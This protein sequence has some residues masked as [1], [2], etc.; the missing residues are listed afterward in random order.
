MNISK[1]GQWCLLL[2]TFSRDFFFIH[3]LH[4]IP[5]I[6]IIIL[7]LSPLCT[8]WT[9]SQQRET[10]KPS[11]CNCVI[12]CTGLGDPGQTTAWGWVTLPFLRVSQGCMVPSVMWT[13]L[14]ECIGK[15]L[16]WTQ[17]WGGRNSLHEHGMPSGEGLSIAV[18]REF[19]DPPPAAFLCVYTHQSSGE[20][21]TQPMF[22]PPGALSGCT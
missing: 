6:T 8:L 16:K 19:P 7:S 10:L 3:S 22:R 9:A 17:D 13:V 21:W 2:L 20:S 11:K 15:K 5:A 4:S 18:C 1:E 12:T 14:R